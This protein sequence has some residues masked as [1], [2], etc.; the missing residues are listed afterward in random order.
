VVVDNPAAVE[1]W[2]ERAL[3]LGASQWRQNA[4]TLGVLAGQLLADLGAPRVE[5]QDVVVPGDPRLELGDVV[6]LT[7]WQERVPDVLARITRIQTTV[8]QDVADQG[9]SGVYGLRIIGDAGG[10]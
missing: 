3:D 7:D 1:V 8:G 2:G 5:V 9:I 6:R 10:G 4:A